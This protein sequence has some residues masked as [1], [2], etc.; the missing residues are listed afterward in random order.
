MN[1]DRYIG[2]PWVFGGRD[3]DGVDCWGLIWL[4]YKHEIGIDIPSYEDAY[5]RGSDAG[6][7]GSLIATQLPGWEINDSPVP[8]NVALI[9][10]AGAACHTGIIAP[11]RR[12][13]HVESD[14]TASIIVPITGSIKRR[15]VGIYRPV[16]P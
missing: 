5:A 16:T 9:K 11:G 13:L 3:F 6:E 14:T 15:I 1:F 4:F 10:R 2:L 8:G 7:I 12:I